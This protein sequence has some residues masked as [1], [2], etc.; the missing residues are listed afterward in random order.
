MKQ[1]LLF[2]LF[3]V[4]LFFSVRAE[5]QSVPGLKSVPKLDVG[6]KIGANFAQIGGTDWV[7]TYQPGIVGGA[8][9]GLHKHKIGVQAEFLVSTAHYTTQG[10]VDS[11]NKGDFRALY[12]DVPVLFEYRLIGGKLLPKIWLMAGPQFSNLMSITSLNSYSG[13]LKNSFKSGSFSG[14]LGAEMRYLKLTVGFR[15]ILGLSNVNNLSVAG[16]TDSWNNH[17]MQLYLGFRFI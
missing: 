5:A 6:L 2:Y 9:I 12:F 7:K 15:Y 10:L 3:P 16:A 1:S 4:V 17:T 13:D 14:V 8:T 11:V